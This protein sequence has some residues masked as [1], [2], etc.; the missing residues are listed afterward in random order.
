LLTELLLRFLIGGVVV[1]SFAFL[2]D[3]FRPKSF[4]GLF[5]AAPSVA[6]ASLSIAVIHD[7]RS[8]AASEAHSMISG[9]VAFFAYASCVSWTMMRQKWSALSASIKCAPV[10]LAIALGL[11]ALFLR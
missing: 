9:A 5:G 6:L 1:S 2:G 11:W 7:G 4:A 10:W 3:L 8:Y